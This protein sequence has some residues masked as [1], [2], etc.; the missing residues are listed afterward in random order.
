MTLPGGEK[1]KMAKI[2]VVDDD[3][4]FVEVTRMILT[5]N[6]YEVISA[7]NSQEALQRMHEDKPDLILLDIM[8]THILD[9]LTVTR[10]MMS[11]PELERVPV[12]VVSAITSSPHIGKF[13]TD[14]YLPVEDW[15]SKPVQPEELLKKVKLYL[16]RFKRNL[17][18][19]K[20]TVEPACS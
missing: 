14:E 19:Q 3:P 13:P 1:V 4:D 10:E 16:R 20:K 18:G 17:E 7:Y 11:D 9:G 5:S 6:G 8:M 2:L 15:I 12:I